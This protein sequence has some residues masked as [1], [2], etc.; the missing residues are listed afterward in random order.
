MNIPNPDAF[1]WYTLAVVCLGFIVWLLQRSVKKFDELLQGLIQKVDK[2]V[3]ISIV[4][5]ERLSVHGERLNGID[6]D[7]QDIKDGKYVVKYSRK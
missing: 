4:H 3:E 2:L 1:F 6:D 7:I 5:G